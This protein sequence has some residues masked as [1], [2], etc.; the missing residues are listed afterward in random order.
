[1]ANLSK[2]EKV[3][4]VFE[5]IAR[6]YD[7]GNKRISLGRER[8]WK[9]A[10]IQRVC[11]YVPEAGAILDVCCGTG[12][13][14]IGIADKRPQCR[15]WG[16]DFSPAMLQ[17]AQEKSKGIKNILWKKGDAVH[18]PFPTAYFDSAVISFGLRN[19]PDYGRVLQE[20]SR[21]VKVGGTIWCLDSFLPESRWIRPWYSLY[22]HYVMPVLGGGRRCRQ[23]YRWLWESTCRFINRRELERLF[24]QAGLT[25]LKHSSYMFGACL[26]QGGLKDSHRK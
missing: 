23:E 5:H 25:L 14:A 2:A 10:L 7:R 26:L 21:V 13:I 11:A 6:T 4:T 17:R 8:V 1:M 9:E 15:V 18:L 22:F 16:L 19:T 20:M 24:V 3:Y 12:D